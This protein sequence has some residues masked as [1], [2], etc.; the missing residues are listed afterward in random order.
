VG[1]A[2]MKDGVVVA[3]VVVVETGALA[4]VEVGNA[5]EVVV[6][7]EMVVVEVDVPV[8]E[9]VVVEEGVVVEVVVVEVGVVELVVVDVDVVV[10]AVVEVVV[11]LGTAASFCN[12]S[13]TVL[14]AVW[15][16]EESVAAAP[17][18]TDRGHAEL[19]PVCTTGK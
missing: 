14:S 12:S 11:V 15:I 3:V 17:E 18:A 5:V 10:V 4:V 2:V 19:R 1:V 7:V 6:V 16:C 13:M 9:L 8:G